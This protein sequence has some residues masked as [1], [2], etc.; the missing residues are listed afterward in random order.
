[1]N[2]S[3]RCRVATPFLGSVLTNFSF[4]PSS[5]KAELSTS[6]LHVVGG[7]EGAV[8]GLAQ[9]LVLRRYVKQLGWWIVATKGGA[10]AT[11]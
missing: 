11:I 8:L 9:W 1:M 3:T 6:P 4:V 2:G 7:L 10:I 5:L